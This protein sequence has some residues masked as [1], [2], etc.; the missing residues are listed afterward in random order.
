METV[1]RVLSIED[2]VVGIK[3]TRLNELKREVNITVTFKYSGEEELNRNIR[4]VEITPLLYWKIKNQKEDYKIGK[5][6]ES[7]N[8]SENWRENPFQ[9]IRYRVNNKDKL[10]LA[11]VNERNSLKKEYSGMFGETIVEYI[12]RFHSSKYY[13][14]YRSYLIES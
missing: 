10:L 8:T 11:C 2:L 5:N 14:R 3:V 1:K 12:N 13:K 7:I 6:Y 9:L 4:G